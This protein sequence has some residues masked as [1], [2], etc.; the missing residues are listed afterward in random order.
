MKGP[1]RVSASHYQQ[2]VVPNYA[3]IKVQV[4]SLL[5]LSAYELSRI[6]P[7]CFLL[8]MALVIIMTATVILPWVK[9]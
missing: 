6:I 8:E 2:E 5:D 3:S 4:N 1:V 7:N 9:K